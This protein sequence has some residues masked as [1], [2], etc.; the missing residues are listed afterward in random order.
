MKLN[1]DNKTW[2]FNILVRNNFFMFKTSLLLLNFCLCVYY[3]SGLISDMLRFPMVVNMK[4][5]LDVI[6]WTN[7]S[8]LNKKEPGETQQIGSETLYILYNRN[9]YIAWIFWLLFMQKMQN[10]ILTFDDL[11]LKNTIIELVPI[12]FE[13]LFK[14]CFSLLT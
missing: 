5:M 6:E 1:E 11:K 4:F 7:S 12:S 2:I 13:L 9:R 3:L 8:I 14:V 10:I